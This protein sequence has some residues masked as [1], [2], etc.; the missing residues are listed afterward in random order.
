MGNV[1]RFHN[2][3]EPETTEMPINH[4]IDKLV[5]YSGILIINKMK[6][7]VESYNSMGES[8]RQYI[9]QKNSGTLKKFTLYGF[10]MYEFLEQETLTYWDKGFTRK[11]QKRTFYS[12]GSFY[13][14]VAV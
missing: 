1:Q 4:G 2:C 7:T 3:S 10:L 13:V 12:D 5:S 11:R 8:F 6:K 14:L 9:G